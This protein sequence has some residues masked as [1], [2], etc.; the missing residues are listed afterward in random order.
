LALTGQSAIDGSVPASSAFHYRQHPQRNC[1]GLSMNMIER[2]QIPRKSIA[3]RLLYTL[4]FLIIF[5]LLKLILL[6]STLFQF[7]YLFL[8]GKYSEPLRH[9]CNRLS[10]YA[11]KIVRFVTLNDNTKPFPFADFPNEMESSEEQVTYQS[12]P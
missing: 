9:F 1:R 7:M 5:E 11:Y 2:L 8:T 6:L 3:I 4:L 12:N 10:S